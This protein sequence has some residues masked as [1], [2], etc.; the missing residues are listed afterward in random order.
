LK[1]EGIASNRC[2]KAIRKTAVGRK[3]DE[4]STIRPGQETELLV[5]KERKMARTNNN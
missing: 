4:K 3:S 2:I 5:W 1:G